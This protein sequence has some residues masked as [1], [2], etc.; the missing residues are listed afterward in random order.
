MRM[1]K[2]AVFG[3]AGGGKSTLSRRLAELTGLPLYVLDKIQ[4]L[5]GGVRVASDVY[6]EIHAQTIASDQW[7]IDGFGSMDTL[8]GR[9]DAADTLIYVDLPIAVHTWWVTKRLLTG[10]ITPPV[11]WPEN[12][13]I[14]KSSMQSYRALWLCHRYLT[15]RYRAYVQQAQSIKTVYHL[16]SP[17]QI[18]QFLTE[19]AQTIVSADKTL[20]KTDDCLRI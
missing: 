10:H 11:G 14:W 19:V 12:S 1:Q 16:R 6:Q 8:W 15:P 9:L 2:V 5:A 13:P 7:I 20:D 18:N 3:N 4:Y 17:A